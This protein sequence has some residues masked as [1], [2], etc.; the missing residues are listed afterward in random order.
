MAGVLFTTL[1]LLSQAG[2]VMAGHGNG[3]PGP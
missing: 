1:M 2:S 3:Y